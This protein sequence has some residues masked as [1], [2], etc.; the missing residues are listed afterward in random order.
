MISPRLKKNR[1]AK[2]VVLA[3]GS[4]SNSS[5]RELQFMFD[6]QQD[7]TLNSEVARFPSPSDV[8]KFQ[9]D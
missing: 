6:N 1:M 2:D 3:K 4:L 9:R 7:T 5:I 8:S